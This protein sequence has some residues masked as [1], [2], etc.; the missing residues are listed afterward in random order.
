MK[1]L[2]IAILIFT[3]AL[4]TVFS[5]A[6]CGDELEM[7]ETPTIEISED[8]YWIINGEKTEVKAAGE[9]GPKGEKGDTGATGEQGPQGEKGDTGEPG[10]D[11]TAT[12]ENVQGLDF[13]LKDDGTYAVGIGTAFYLS[14]IE[15]PATYKGKAVTE[16]ASFFPE[17]VFK[18]YGS[19]L[20]KIIIPEGVT[21]IVEYAFEGCES[22]LSVTIPSTVKFIGEDAFDDCD[23]L[24]EVINNSS[25]DITAGSSDY[26][27][28]ALNAL[29]VHSGE[30]KLVKENGYFFYSCN[31]KNYLLG[32]NGNETALTLPDSFKG[33]KYVINN[34][35]F[36]DSKI[37]SVIISAGVTEIGESA[38]GSCHRLT[39]V[40]IGDSVTSIGKGA[41]YHC[42]SLVSVTIPDSVTNIGEYAF[43]QCTGLTDVTIPDSV[44][45]MGENAF[46]YC[47]NLIIYC[48][49]AS[50][51]S[52][53][54]SVW[55]PSKKPVVWDCVNNDVADNGNIY[56]TVEG[57][58]YTLKD[59]VAVVEMQPSASN[60]TTANIPAAV[61]YKD[62]AYNVIGISDYA[63]EYC[64][65]LTSVTIPDSVTEIGNYAFC[66]CT[67]LTSVTIPDSVTN[68][69]RNAFYGC[70][71]LTSV[72]IPDSVASIGEGAFSACTS[73]T[74]VYITDIAKWCAIDFY[75]SYSNPLCN[76]KNLYVNNTL[77]TE[78]VIPNGVTSIGSSA[79]S[80][81]TSL[82]SVTI[83]NS[84][85]SIRDYAFSGCTSLKSVTIPNSV[86]SIRDYAFSGCTSLTSVTIPDSVTSIGY[87]AFCY[88]TSLIEINFNATAMSDLSFVNYVFSNAGKN[89]EGIKVTIGKN[90][91]KI[92][93]RLFYD[94]YYV[95]SVEFEEGSVCESIG[96]S[97]FEYCASLTSVTIPDSVTSIGSSAFRGCISLTSIYVGE[98]N[99]AYKSIDGNLYTKDG[100]TLIQYAI[101]KTDTS[102]IIPDSVETIGGNAFYNCSNLS[103]LTLGNSVQH[104]G[105]YAFEY[106]ASLTSVTIPD[107]VTS[108]GSYAFY[109][110]TSLTIYCEAASKPSG[111][112]YDWNYSNCP[113]VWDCDN[114]GGAEDNV[115]NQDGT[116]VGEPIPIPKG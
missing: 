62:T 52:S 7:I 75:D 42:N 23:S 36:Y 85:T 69:G 31:D 10:K 65:S 72:T 79:F 24:V 2:F 91:T 32:Y 112:R 28:I 8:G 78:L 59:S 92:P 47:N 18:D 16:I 99:T 88:C 14:E 114:N 96:S 82:K 107:S 83:P 57:I 63:F 110:C 25:L 19:R 12:D 34:N 115:W 40:I 80:G 44:I 109:N 81:C 97:A 22:L 15:I 11:L 49:A 13:Y 53:W 106:C 108:I 87:G 56:C 100:K 70:T 48:E 89:G 103:E 54:D 90:V 61:T 5:L 73:I 104:I 33:E 37:E 68:I 71:S 50:Q 86:T 35:A 9:Q 116:A 45:G 74:S 17:E 101:G 60:I 95:T 43:E 41:F 94:A 55:N 30:S 102:F 105:S 98:N 6:S 46:Y 1:K 58:R 27:Q 3:L 38:F 84:V 67:S 113:V 4:G 77:V 29:E 51:P 76:A 39:E 111:W 93:A 20:R 64:T 66:D 26:G 21:H